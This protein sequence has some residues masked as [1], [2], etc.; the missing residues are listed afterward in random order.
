MKLKLCSILCHLYA[1][2]IMP[3]SGQ[4]HSHMEHA[5][6]QGRHVG[7]QVAIITSECNPED[8]TC[9]PPPVQYLPDFTIQFANNKGLRRNIT[10]IQFI[11]PLSPHPSLQLTLNQAMTTTTLHR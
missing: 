6:C 7:R 11:F 10:V 2:S 8:Y 5:G 9:K 1:S 3:N 4:L